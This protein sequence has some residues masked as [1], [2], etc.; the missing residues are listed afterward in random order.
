MD[1]VAYRF[2][3]ISAKAGALVS[4]AAHMIRLHL[5][6]CKRASLS[7]FT[8]FLDI[9]AAYYKLLRQHSLG[10]DT[11]DEGIMT[12]LHRMGV[13][14]T[15]LQEVAEAIVEPAILPSTGC[16]PHLSS[17]VKALHDQTW[18]IMSGDRTMIQTSRG[19]RPGDGFADV[20]WNITYA[21]FLQRVTARLEATGAFSSLSWNEMPGLLCD[22]GSHWSKH[23]AVTWADDT[24]L[25]GWCTRATQLI[26]QL[27]VTS[28][29]V[30]SELLRLGMSP[31]VDA[32]KTEAIVDLRGPDS[33]QCRRYLHGPCQSKVELS[34][35]AAPELSSLRIVAAYNHLGGYL[36]HGARY[37]TEIKRRVA[38]ALRTLALHRTKV[39]GNV[40]I[41]LP[42]RVA[43]YRS[44]AHL[45]LCYNIGTWSMLNQAES[46]AWH[47]GVLKIYRRLLHRI[48]PHK[49]QLH[50]T[51]GMV[52][53]LTG[54]PHPQDLLHLE[55]LRQFG[56]SLR[57]DTPYFWTLVANEQNWLALVRE[58]FTWLYE[59]IQG[60][61]TL[62][63]PHEDP[64]TWHQLIIHALPK[65]KNVLKRGL[66]HSLGQRLLRHD[67]EQFRRTL[68]K[69]LSACGLVLPRSNSEEAAD[70][71]RCLVCGATFQT[72]RGWA[73]HSFD[74]HGRLS[75]FR[76]LDDGT[77]CKACGKQF[78][79]NFRLVRHFRG[80]QRCAATVAS[81]G[82]WTAPQPF[83]GSAQV[84]EVRSADA[85]I[86]WMP[87][88]V[89]CLEP[90]AGWAMNK[91]QLDFLKLMAKF[92]WTSE[93]VV[94][95]AFPQLRTFLH[96]TP[97]HSTEV[98]EAFDAYKV[99][100]HEDAAHDH[101]QQALSDCLRLF[102]PA[103]LGQST[104]TSTIEFDLEHILN[105][106]SSA[107]YRPSPPST[108]GI[109][110]FLY[111]LHLFSGVKRFGDLHSHV[112]EL[113]RKQGYGLCPIS[114][115][116]ALHAQH[117][118][119]LNPV[120]QSFWLGKAADG[121]LFFVV[122]G[123]PCESWS[124]ARF[125]YLTEGEGPRPLRATTPSAMLWG[126]CQLKLKELKQVDFGN[127]LLQ[128]SMT[129]LALQ[130][131]SGNNG[132]LEHPACASQRCGL[133]PPS[134]WL[135]PEM[136]T[137]LRHSRSR[138]VHLCQG[139]FGARSPKPTSFLLVADPAA[140]DMMEQALI[141]GQT[142]WRLPPPLKMGKTSEG[143]ATN[144][145]KRYPPPLCGA[146]AKMIGCAVNGGLTADASADD[147]IHHI[148]AML[149]HGYEVVQD[150]TDGVDAADFHNATACN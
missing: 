119:L 63:P 85:M 87:S 95:Q 91:C 107:T 46:K 32:G 94:D 39:F 122:C 136:V 81:L 29:I 100:Y 28:E 133:Q 40:N 72:Y 2:V 58:S 26:P 103:D 126:K 24:A 148:A 34:V 111:V 78:P 68:Y 75:R 128:F 139:H 18:Y 135:L 131:L 101:L 55:R 90:R 15:T 31:N 79:S 110:R 20:I 37:M 123:P 71:H 98:Q 140:G 137:F 9:Q 11:S 62:P 21:K 129:I 114:V 27:R 118:D 70:P 112:D 44:T 106:P 102:A 10:L 36:V 80:N 146:I 105:E 113:A 25:M 66:A 89:A 16:P 117:G 143:Y 93:N 73:V 12:L 43:L 115:D 121:F 144:P 51:D 8:L 69:T 86:P 99:Y 92:E 61:T 104:T 60:L 49:Q 134:I 150:A 116:V 83:L 42:R 64:D 149:Q 53:R 108:R 14:D 5:G 33:L 109:P 125:R 84:A 41:D 19:T 6:L 141:N 65:W 30:F 120:T 50:L 13:R 82:A 23:F 59:Q 88:D 47:S 147:G 4:H 1:E 35:E 56:L 48:V 67:V 54:L 77:L 127:R 17:M 145:L 142:Q 57:R 138:L 38:M 52:L 74:S 124:V 96:S 22:T 76:Q 130:L 7:G 97:V 3:Q 45:S 132:L